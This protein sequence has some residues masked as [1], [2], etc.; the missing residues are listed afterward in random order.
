M[1]EKGERHM[2]VLIAKENVSFS[3]YF[4]PSSTFL[5][6]EKFG[7]MS[8]HCLAVYRKSLIAQGP[9]QNIFLG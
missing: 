9:V 8:V 3:V 7:F 6:F 5:V 1:K 4:C 2:S